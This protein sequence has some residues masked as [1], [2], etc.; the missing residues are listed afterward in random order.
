M[1]EQTLSDHLKELKIRLIYCLAALLLAFALS[2]NFSSQIYNFLTQ[3]L[4]ASFENPLDQRIIYTNLT[5]AFFTYLKLS[6]LAAFFFTFPFIALQFYLFLAPALYKKEKKFT[7]NIIFFCPLLFILGSVMLYEIVLPLAFKFFISFQN[8]N[9][10]E[11]LPVEL[12]TK[13]SEYLS[14]VTKM[15]FAFGFAFQMPIIL[16]CLVKFGVLSLESL[17][18]KRKYWIVAI[19]T[20]AA[21]I[22]PPDL[23][24]QI[25]LALPM[26]LLYEISIIILGFSH[27]KPS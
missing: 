17:K 25:T 10:P 22:T 7:L 6:F 5:E 9:P 11:A 13:I 4:I 27:K 8:L 14:L 1:K 3:P 15:L 24:S 12:E 2:Y 26:I 23:I 19:F 16:I 21:I 18:K 20:I